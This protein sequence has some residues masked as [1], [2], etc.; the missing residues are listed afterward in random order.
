M[1]NK[2]FPLRV[3][4]PI[5]GNDEWRR[6]VNWL[7]DKAAGRWHYIG[8]KTSADSHLRVFAFRQEQDAMM[9]SLRWS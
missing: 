6:V 7:E 4:V 3:A 8:I 9:F 2:I 1:I 5:Y